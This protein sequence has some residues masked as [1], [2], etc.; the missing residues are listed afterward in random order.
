[1]CYTVFVETPA[2][3]ALH[4]VTLTAQQHFQYNYKG[5]LEKAT[6]YCKQVK[7]NEASC[8]KPTQFQQ[9]LSK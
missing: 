5:R 9:C 3:V 4:Q 6:I 1:M 7:Q 2:T 8:S